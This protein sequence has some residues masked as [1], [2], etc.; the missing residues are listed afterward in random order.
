MNMYE[1]KGTSAI[2]AIETINAKDVTNAKRQ[3]GRMYGLDITEITAKKIGEVV[4]ACNPAPA[5]ME[6]QEP[7]ACICE[8]CGQ[9]IVNFQQDFYSQAE[10][11]E[12][13][14]TNCNCP[15][16]ENYQKRT[17][18]LYEAKKEISALLPDFYSQEKEYKIEE[19]LNLMSEM[20]FDYHIT[21]GNIKVN[22]I[23]FKVARTRNKSISITRVKT[24]TESR[25]V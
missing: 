11:D 4:H 16:A 1:V 14:K 20:A 18:A 19:L 6:P 2:S 24:D 10:A 25:E 3:Y 7:I 9:A 21:T 22:N 15:G 23:Q 5:P 12:Y 17:V 13:A 8:F